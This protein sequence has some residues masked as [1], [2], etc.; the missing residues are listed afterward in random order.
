MKIFSNFDTKLRQ[1]TFEEY[2]EKC[3]PEN[4]LCFWRSRLYRL[5][6]V[7]FPLLFLTSFAA[8]VLVFFYGR[9]GGDYF[10]YIVTAIIII[11][12]VFFFPVIG[13]YID[14]KMDF[15]IVI[16]NTIMMY[17]QWGIFKRN[18][19]TISSQSIRSVSIK[20]AGLLYSMFDNGDIVI[21]TQGDTEDNSEVVLRR[22]PRPEKRKNQILKIIGMDLQANQNPKI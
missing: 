9:L 10:G 13:K 19:V 21:L 4:V 18:V 22:I 16:Q 12:I 2:Q 1:K 14:Y 5:Y 20:K 17:D 6:K 11:F 3:G 7:V 8:L 15:I